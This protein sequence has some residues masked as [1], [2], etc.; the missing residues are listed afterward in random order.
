MAASSRYPLRPLPPLL[1]EPFLRFNK[2]LSGGTR[3]ATRTTDAPRV[4][5][6]RTAAASA[7]AAQRWLPITA[8]A[9]NRP[10]R[11]GEEKSTSVVPDSS[12]FCRGFDVYFARTLFSRCLGLG[13]TSHYSME[14]K[15]REESET[16]YIASKRFQQFC[17]VK[18]FRDGDAYHVVSHCLI[19]IS[20]PINYLGSC[21]ISAL[22]NSIYIVSFRDSLIRRLINW[23]NLIACRSS[24]IATSTLWI[25]IV[26][27]RVCRWR[28]MRRFWNTLRDTILT[29]EVCVSAG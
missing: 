5:I 3:N 2:L 27:A 7:D 20:M 9:R 8:K 21:H 28:F 1:K 11:D 18:L 10:A 13:S 4:Y 29:R 14:G 19:L 25:F 16:S 24:V 26:Q 12:R 17:N 15:G 6:W 23:L 22:L